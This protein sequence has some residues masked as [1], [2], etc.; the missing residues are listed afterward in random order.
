MINVSFKNMKFK[1]R[2]KIEL[3]GCKKEPKIFPSSRENVKVNSPEL[4]FD[5][6]TL[7]LCDVELFW[8]INALSL[9]TETIKRKFSVFPIF[10]FI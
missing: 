3:N 6:F 1:K 8:E 10:Y 9:T 7:S 4:N 2:S 5:G